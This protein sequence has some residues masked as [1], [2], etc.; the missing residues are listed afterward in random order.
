LKRLLTLLPLALFA[1]L[2]GYFALGLQ[3]DPHLLPSAMI[4][5]PAPEFA[6]PPLLDDKPG[7]ARAD[8]ADGPVLV[9]FFASWCVPCRA[10]H[11]I[12][13]RIAGEGVRID[14]IDYKDKPDDAKRWLTELGDPYRRLA[15]D[16]DGRVAIDFGVY[17]VPETYVVDRAGKIRYRQVGPITPDDLAR[18]IRPLLAE[19]SK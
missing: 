3:H 9:N 19:L 15:V 11:P 5:K 16:R 7:L 13:A 1:V 14:G 18:T 8:L 6:L 17:G 10:E 4:D 2:I 12:L